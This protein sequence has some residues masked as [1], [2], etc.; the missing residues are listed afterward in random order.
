MIGK[1]MTLVM[2]DGKQLILYIGFFHFWILADLSQLHHLPCRNRGNVWCRTIAELSGWQIGVGDFDGEFVPKIALNR[3]FRD[4]PLRQRPA[5]F[6][7]IL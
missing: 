4:G 2:T 1:I 7:P 3:S 6:C 5:L